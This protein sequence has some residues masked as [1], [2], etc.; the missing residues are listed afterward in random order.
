VRDRPWTKDDVAELRRLAPSY[1]ASEVAAKLGRRP[2]DI[3]LKARD[4]RISL[5]IKS[6]PGPSRNAPK[7]RSARRKARVGK[8]PGPFSFLGYGREC[9]E[10]AIALPVRNLSYFLRFQ[11][12]KF[13]EKTTC[14]ASA[15]GARTTS[16]SSIA[17]RVGIL[18]HR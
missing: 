18:P 3:S 14:R 9:T 16:L 12:R 17:W 6:R 2:L 13:W 4:L 1:P 10:R 7:R 8:P 11:A 5:R 15:S